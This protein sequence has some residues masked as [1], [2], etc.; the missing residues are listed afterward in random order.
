MCIS[1]QPADN[2][3]CPVQWLVAD[4]ILEADGAPPEQIEHLRHKY[5]GL[6]E[7]PETWEEYRD[8]LGHS[9]IRD[10]G[11]FRLLRRKRRQE[12]EIHAGGM[13]WQS[14]EVGF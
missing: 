6:H 4:G 2:Q 1:F 10:L 8:D 13:T 5:E 9:T 11:G 3:F 12:A 14:I 7:A